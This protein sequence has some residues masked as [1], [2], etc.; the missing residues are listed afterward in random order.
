MIFTKKTIAL[1]KQNNI[2]IDHVER[3]NPTIIVVFKEASS[4]FIVF[5]EILTK[6]YYTKEPLDIRLCVDP[7]VEYYAIVDYSDEEE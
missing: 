2:K 4:A 7:E 3:L 1:M 6:Y 5:N